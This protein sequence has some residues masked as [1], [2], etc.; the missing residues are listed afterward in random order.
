LGDIMQGLDKVISML[1]N[2]S[3]K[4]FGNIL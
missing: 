4:K 3:K 2:W 1:M